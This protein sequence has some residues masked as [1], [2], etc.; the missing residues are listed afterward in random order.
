ML[1]FR[2]DNLANVYGSYALAPPKDEMTGALTDSGFD[3]TYDEAGLMGRGLYIGR[4]IE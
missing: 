3:V 1:G 4:R 2:L